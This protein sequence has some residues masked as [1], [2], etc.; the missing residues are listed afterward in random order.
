MKPT[1][2]T[3]RVCALM[4]TGWVEQLDDSPHAHQ[5]TVRLPATVRLPVRRLDHHQSMT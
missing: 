1:W 2:H 4:P 3:D 5:T